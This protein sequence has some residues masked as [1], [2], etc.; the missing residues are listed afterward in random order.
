MHRSKRGRDMITDYSR[1]VFTRFEAKISKEPP[2]L[3][4]MK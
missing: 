2:L 1:L 4:E 3:T